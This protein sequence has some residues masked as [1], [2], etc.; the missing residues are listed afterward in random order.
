[1]V[2]T[3]IPSNLFLLLV[4][5]MPTQLTAIAMLLLRACLSQMDVPTRQ[6]YV[7]AVVAPDERSA[8]N[9]VTGVARTTGSALSPALAGR[10][11][12]SPA[13]SGGIFVVAGALKLVYDV[14]LYVSFRRRRPSAA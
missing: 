1:M 14:L 5:F 12:A 6:S 2:F 13:L 4:P 9:G 8:A 11:L 7:A 10:L 3:H